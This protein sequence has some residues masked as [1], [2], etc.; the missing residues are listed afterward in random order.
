MI[1]N[2]KTYEFQTRSDAPNSNFINDD[3]FIIINDD[4]EIAKKIQKFYPF[5]KVIENQNGEIIDIIEDNEAKSI[6]KSILAK[7]LEI[8]DLKQKLFDTDYQAIKYAEGQL[9]EDE[10]QPIKEQR[11]A[12]RDEINKLEVE[13]KCQ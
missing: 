10:Y 2:K 1:F 9:S 4:S 7:S 6:A 3:N 5:M 12:W 8:E 13:Q 11:Q